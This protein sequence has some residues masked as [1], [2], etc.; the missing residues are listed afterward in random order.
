[1]YKAIVFSMLFVYIIAPCLG[2]T[3]V[4]ESIALALGI[5]FCSYSVSKIDN[6]DIIRCGHVE[7]YEE[8]FKACINVSDDS[9]EET[10]KPKKIARPI[11]S[12]AEEMVLINKRLAKSHA[13][14]A[15]KLAKSLAD[16]ERKTREIAFIESAAKNEKYLKQAYENSNKPCDIVARPSR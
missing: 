6:L 10:I 4:I 11:R 7:T 2:L 9:D 5:P 8:L 16:A 3:D 1:M 15:E 14:V 13:I 12:F